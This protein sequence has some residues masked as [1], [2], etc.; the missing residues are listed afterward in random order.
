MLRVCKERW[1]NLPS[2]EETDKVSFWSRLSVFGDWV[3]IEPAIDNQLS[4]GT[5]VCHFRLGERLHEANM[6]FVTKL[7]NST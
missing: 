4:I 2:R 1:E 7:Y 6:S 5:Q 3:R